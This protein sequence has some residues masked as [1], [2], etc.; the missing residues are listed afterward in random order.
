MSIIND[1]K[2]VLSLEKDLKGR[3]LTP[4]EEIDA[5]RKMV[6]ALDQKYRSNRLYF[7]QHRW[8]V[9][10]Y[11]PLHL[12]YYKD[13]HTTSQNYLLPE[14]YNVNVATIGTIDQWESWTGQSWEELIPAFIAIDKGELS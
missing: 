14:E 5:I 1:I 4:I 11:G 3:D 6:L 12:I 7:L 2:T 8:E 10:A 9:G 13:L